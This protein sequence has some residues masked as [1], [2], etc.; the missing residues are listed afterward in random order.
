MSVKNVLD[1]LHT[2]MAEVV[3]LRHTASVLEWDE[4][5]Y[6]PPGGASA[7]SSAVATVRR[8]AHEKFTSAEIGELLET[9]RAG[10]DGS[11]VTFETTRLIAVTAR[12]YEKATRVPASFVA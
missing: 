6:M 3:D 10:A 1:R 7:R 12:D 2:L 4:R 5:T 9:L 8:I 11:E